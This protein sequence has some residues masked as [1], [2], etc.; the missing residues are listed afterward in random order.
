MKTARAFLCF[1][2]LGGEV[3]SAEPP[4]LLTKALGT[5]PASSADGDSGGASFS[6][7]GRFLLFVSSADNL[8]GN[9]HN[10]P[11]LDVFV[12][13]LRTGTV[14]LVSVTPDGSDGGNANS[15]AASIS[16]DGQWVVFSSKATNIVPGGAKG[17]RD[18]FLRDLKAGITTRMSVG[19][20]GEP[21]NGSS[22]NPVVTPD[23]EWVMFES[24]AS[25]LV[26]GDDN[27]YGDVFIRNVRTGVTT[28]VSAASD[29]SGSGL[30]GGSDRAMSSDD[31]RW[32]AFSSLATNLVADIGGATT[33]L[34]LRD[35][36]LGSTRR[37]LLEDP[38]LP[39]GTYQSFKHQLSGDGRYLAF[40]FA[41]YVNGPKS[42]IYWLDVVAGTNSLPSASVDFPT[43]LSDTANGPVMSRNGR[44]I[45]W[46]CASFVGGTN[47]VAVWD[48]AVGG[49]ALRLNHDANSPVISASHPVLSRDGTRLAFVSSASNLVASAKISAQRLYLRHLPSGTDSLVGM[50]L[51]NV[52]AAG[53][54]IANAL[55]SPDGRTLVF[56][57]QS[58]DLVPRD[59]N[60]AVDLFAV[61]ASVMLEIEAILTPAGRLQ[62]GWVAVGGRSYVIRGRPSLD[63][64]WEDVISL[65]AVSS[66]FLSRELEIPA[67]PAQSFFQALALP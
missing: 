7:D 11:T 46:N 49:G 56:E 66:G 43:Y 5:D 28:L 14:T 3:L 2:A 10:G 63:Q 51:G 34:Y 59:A 35:L 13:E 20:H 47:F 29:G 55:F 64:E 9:C 58:A 39:P 4:I 25:N 8:V 26:P 15:D 62:L 37:I 21:A 17:V 57:S 50:S 41:G 65:K 44:V 24:D 36:S 19:P 42:G 18:V 54:D 33:D 30:G 53:G 45:A 67:V 48:A 60:G 61:D 12:R 27:G 40:G 6:D 32:V 16:N 22:R 38:G 52:A 1:L 23:G 31:G